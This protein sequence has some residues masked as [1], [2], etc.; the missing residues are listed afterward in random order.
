MDKKKLRYAILK[1]LD[2]NEDNVTADYFGIT[3][4]EFF[5]NVIFLDREGYI[6]KP[7]YGSNMVYGMGLS[8]IT[9]K[10]ENYLEENSKLSKGYKVAKEIRDWIKF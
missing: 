4:K 10:G 7:M 1:K 8:R 5:E 9:E 6:T 3:G 2:V